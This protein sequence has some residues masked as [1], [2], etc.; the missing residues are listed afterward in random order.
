MQKSLSLKARIFIFFFGIL[1]LMTGTYIFAVSRFITRS[2]VEQLDAD[3]NEILSQTCDTVEG[4]LWNLTLSSQQLLENR[5]IRQSLTG[6]LHETDPYARQTYY[7]NLLETVAS[8]T[9]SNS[10]VALFYF[11]EPQS[12]E[13]IYSSLPADRM[14]GSYPALCRNGDFLFQGPCKSQSSFISNP[15]VLLNRSGQLDNDSEIVLSMESGYY[16]LDAPL[17]AA[18]RK[19]AYLAFWNSDGALVYDTLPQ[20]WDS[21]ALL[22]DITAGNHPDFRCF[23]RQTQQGW[24]VSIVIPSSVYDKDYR[25]ALQD[26]IL[27]TTVAAVFVGAFAIYF[28]KSIY[29]PLQ[30]FDSQL[31]T[32]LSSDV[33]AER[34]HS[35]IPE[36]EHLLG[37]I[38]V[39]QKQIQSMLQKA[40]EQEKRNARIQTEKLRAQINP[41][42]LMNTLNTLHW[43][44]LM[45][46][47][48]DMDRITQSLTHLLS[49]NLDK[50]SEYTNL[51]NELSA[52]KEY[53]ALQQV[54]Y[55]LQF[56]IDVPQEPAGLNYPC[57]KFILQPLA[58]NALMHAYKE[59]MTIAVKVRVD[60]EWISV[61]LRDTGQGM[62]EEALRQLRQKLDRYASSS[63]EEDEVRPGIGLQ[64]VV[65]SLHTFYHGIY[66]FRVESRQGEGTEMLLRL[67]KVRGG[68]Y[69]A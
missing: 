16:S 47:Q 2:T 3:Y 57:P 5:D 40:V 25:L 12:G 39:L 19:S 29:H 13:I 53:M 33:S 8:L 55:Q 58:E 14:E 20:E 28:W 35:S 59:G 24:G 65:R 31:N 11:L 46:H 61:S 7:G 68:G 43:M 64:Y 60:D 1:L 69:H 62:D 44:A 34:F 48:P 18:E 22:S 32:L 45:N 9:M 10:D 50:E 63:E 21:A 26:F 23:S 51:K 67:P 4:T 6:Y 66:E 41:H 30:L 49:Y 17:Q 38:S 15:V 42:F 54:R 56:E 52:L 36:Y 27:S 37:R